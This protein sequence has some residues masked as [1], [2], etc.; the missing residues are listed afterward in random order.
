MDSITLHSFFVFSPGC[1]VFSDYSISAL[2]L[3]LAV[4]LK[5]CMKFLY[6][7]AYSSM[8]GSISSIFYCDSF[9][10]V[11][12]I[13][14]KYWSLFLCSKFVFRYEHKSSSPY[15]CLTFDFFYL[16]FILA[17]QSI[18]E[19]GQF[20]K[21]TRHTQINTQKN[22]TITQVKS[23][24]IQTRISDPFHSLIHI[25][26][27]P[28]QSDRCFISARVGESASFSNRQKSGSPSFSG[29]SG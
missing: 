2:A 13:S 10:S 8:T 22:I 5:L 11:C 16:I 14:S 25:H 9:E 26:T 24:R 28:C 27:L 7:D 15:I 1:T 19:F 21:S 6:C 4:K 17:F 3:L 18:Y 29:P 23:Q 20:L 12:R